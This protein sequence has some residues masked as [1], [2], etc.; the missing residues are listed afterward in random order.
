VR[1]R[2]FERYVPDDLD[3]TQPVDAYAA[4]VNFA[5]GALS[6]GPV[7]WSLG[8]ADAEAEQAAQAIALLE[9]EGLPFILGLIRDEDLRD[10]MIER[11]RNGDGAYLRLLSGLV[12]DLGPA[13][14]L[15]WIER[16][17][18]AYERDLQAERDAIEAE[19]IADAR[20]QGLDVI[21]TS[22]ATIIQPPRR[23]G[24]PDPRPGVLADHGE[25]SERPMWQCSLDDK[26]LGSAAEAGGQ[27]E[28][29][30]SDDPRHTSLR[31]WEDRAILDD[32]DRAPDIDIEAH[33]ALAE[34]CLRLARDAGLRAEVSSGL[35][36]NEGRPAW[37]P[38]AELGPLSSAQERRVLRD[39][40]SSDPDARMTALMSAPACAPTADLLASITELLA[41]G[42]LHHRAFAAQAMG[43]LGEA[44]SADAITAV[45]AEITATDDPQYVVAG[46][47][48]AIG[49][50][51]VA[52]RF[53]DRLPA[54]LETLETV[55][56]RTTGVAQER[57]RALIRDL[58]A[59]S[60]I[61]GQSG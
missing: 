43:V 33:R 18:V 40:R 39:L 8:N 20:A 32:R 42:S 21:Q 13:G 59:R 57:I 17:L 3:P 36:E 24:R 37:T 50:G 15:P 28:H 54:V 29:R 49:L 51:N 31:T 26:A 10:W 47:A 35:L 52:L 22:G 55:A 5:L 41:Q 53:P 16:E 46:T 4:S 2:Q 60:D 23:T 34:G 61:G 6:V 19:V 56:P 38:I 48:A 11:A 25:R 9:A 45:L 44:E 14:A 27:R 30:Y 58:R 1:C 12:A 7:I